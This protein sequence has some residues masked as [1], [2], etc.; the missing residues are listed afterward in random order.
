MTKS[1]YGRIIALT[2]MTCI[3]LLGI[4]FIACTAH[5]Y[6]TGGDQP[7]S[8]ERVGKYLI[9][10][11]VPSFITIASVVC[12]V[13]YNLKTSETDVEKTART[14]V[15]LL[16]SL[17]S[18]YDFAGFPD[19]VRSAVTKERDKRKLIKWISYA[20]SFLL[21]LIALLYF[22]LCTSFSVENLN[23]DVLLAL[24]G[25]LPLSVMAV[26]IHIPKEYLIERSAAKEIVLI[27][28]SI[29][30]NGAPALADKDSSKGK[31]AIVIARYVALGAA[32]LLIIL[33][34]INGGMADVL[35]KAV[36][37]CTECI[38]LG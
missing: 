10:L 9:V 19:E 15:E 28:E 33:G 2:T 26:A 23:G 32:A 14:N 35:N 36:K 31:N 27:K 3:I 8:R 22:Y 5:L 29:K 24:A 7:Y 13:I 18:R 4:M 16:D 6:F 21:T 1:K 38:G 30:T 37:I 25:V 17:A 12:G 11:A 34:I 20:I